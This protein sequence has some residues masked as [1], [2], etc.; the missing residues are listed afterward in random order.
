MT[1]GEAESLGELSRI[2]AAFKA[3]IRE[4]FERI[5]IRLDKLEFVHPSV[6]A[7]DRHT[8]QERHNA[9]A[10]RVSRIE[11]SVQ[12]AIRTLGAT[13]ITLVAGAIWLLATGNQP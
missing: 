4:D 7:A 1:G 12:W 9:L 5:N 10:D 6:Y 8:D 3:D 2:I 13:I 11:S